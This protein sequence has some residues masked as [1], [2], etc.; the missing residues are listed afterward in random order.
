MAI[1]PNITFKFIITNKSIS[2]SSV[3]NNFE[4]RKV[5]I[6]INSIK[7]SK[8]SLRSMNKLNK[9]DYTIEKFRQ[10]TEQILIS[11]KNKMQQIREEHKQLENNR[12]ILTNLLKHQNSHTIILTEFQKNT[13]IYV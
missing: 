4:F 10:E 6:D 9:E 1:Y 13:L 8:S 2:L 5:E 11:I 12:D 7:Y 3:E